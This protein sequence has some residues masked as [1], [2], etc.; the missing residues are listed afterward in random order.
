VAPAALRPCGSGSLG[1][2]F[3][4]VAVSLPAMTLVSIAV[5]ASAPVARG[6]HSSTFQ[7]NVSAFCGTGSASKDCLGAVSGVSGGITECAGCVFVSET[8][9]V[10]LKSGRL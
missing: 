6:L 2:A 10:K 1:L 4:T 3:D 5:M 8:A 9:Q 7:L